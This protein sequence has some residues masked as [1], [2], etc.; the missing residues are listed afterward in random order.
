MVNFFYRHYL[1][2]LTSTYEYLRVA[3]AATWVHPNL[4]NVSFKQEK[5]QS[6]S[7]FGHQKKNSLPPISFYDYSPKPLLKAVENS[8][9]KLRKSWN[10]TL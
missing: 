9:V 1:G 2:V 4:I 5:K 10:I 7:P 3:T 6:A 8:K